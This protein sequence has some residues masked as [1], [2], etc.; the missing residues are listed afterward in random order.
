MRLLGC[1][2]FAGFGLLWVV[3][4]SALGLGDRE[5]ID[6]YPDGREKVV[7]IQDGDT[8][9]ELYYHPNGQLA[10]EGTRLKN[11]AGYDGDVKLYSEKGQRMT[12]AEF[13]STSV[14]RNPY[15]SEAVPNSPPASS[16][17]KNPSPLAWWQFWRWFEPQP[18]K[19]STPPSHPSSDK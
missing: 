17:E 18:Q 19:P 3:G 16:P 15:A 5:V 7:H 6:R 14:S 13:Y 11:S 12:P 1:L 9:R 10:F 2:L 4:C 8:T